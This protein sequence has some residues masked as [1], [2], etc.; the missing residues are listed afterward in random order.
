MIYDTDALTAEVQ[1]EGK[2][3]SKILSSVEQVIVGQRNLVER[4]LI[5][6][7]FRGRHT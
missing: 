2:F 3:I 7:E 1:E 4:I 5:A 6:L